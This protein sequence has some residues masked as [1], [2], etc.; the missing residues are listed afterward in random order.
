[1]K[2]YVVVSLVIHFV[3]FSL[4]S[5][6]GFK[7]GEEIVYV[8]LIATETRS[9]EV[10]EVRARIEKSVKSRL[11]KPKP[12]RVREPR[13]KVSKKTRSKETKGIGK[14]RKPKRSKKGLRGESASERVSRELASA[15]VRSILEGV[16]REVASAYESEKRM[17][18]YIALVKAGIKENWELPKALKGKAESLKCIISAVIKE[19]GMLSSVYIE[20]SSGDKLFDD[21]AVQ[22]LKKSQPLP[23]PPIGG[24]EIGFIFRGSG[25]E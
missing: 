25:P 1:M 12:K 8:S 6:G 11:E 22:T 18:I 13:S 3:L 14:L 17:R 19:D 5:F 2:P 4:S 21:W 16:K 20:E 24:V 15:E 7:R 10:K 9:V 23:P